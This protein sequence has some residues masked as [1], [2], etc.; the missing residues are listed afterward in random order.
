MPPERAL[1]R[2]LS[3]HGRRAMPAAHR[4][5]V[6][7]YVFLPNG[8][9][10]GLHKSATALQECNKSAT[11]GGPERAAHQRIP[12]TRTTYTTRKVVCIVVLWFYRR[13][14]TGRDAILCRRECDADRHGSKIIAH[15]SENVNGKV[16]NLY[17]RRRADRS[18]TAG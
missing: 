1:R 7:R 9:P 5:K 2:P 12:T 14:R 16:K 10:R 18:H 8:A 11:A 13:R 17:D 3:C 15:M 6:Q 4:A